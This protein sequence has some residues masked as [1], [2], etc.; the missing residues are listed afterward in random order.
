MKLSD[1]KPLDKM[2]YLFKGESGSGKSTAAA[3]FASLGKMYWFDLDGRMAPLVHNPSL[4]HLVDNIEFDS[5]VN[6]Q[7]VVNKLEQFYSSCPY[8]TIVFDSLTS[9]ARLAIGHLFDNR[10]AQKTRKDGTVENLNVGGIPVM[11]INE[12]G[13]ETSG[14]AS[15][16]LNLRV[17]R[18]HGTNVIFVAHVVVTE[19]QTLTGTKTTRR[20]LTG[21]NKIASEIPTYFDEVYHFYSTGSGLSDETSFRAVTMSNGTDYARTSFFG[22]Q[23]EIEFTNALF[24]NKLLE[25]IKSSDSQSEDV[26]SNQ[27]EITNQWQS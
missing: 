1:Y 14:I 22:L 9:F 27:S 5:F 7:D 18:N 2:M 17:I 10:G 19:S 21:G 12:Y 25:A 20:I 8:R 26:K 15:A 4:R 13:G 3:S 23:K 16:L 11:G 24:Y 6:Y